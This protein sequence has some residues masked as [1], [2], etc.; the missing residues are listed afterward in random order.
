MNPLTPT[1]TK[2]AA[3]PPAEPSV[4]T[5]AAQARIQ[6]LRAM[7]E[8]IPEF[9]IP[10]SKAEARRIVA[11]ASVPPEFVELAATAITL[12]PDLRRET[13]DP[14]RVRDRMDYADAYSPLADQ[15]EAAAKFLRH[16]I[17]V[18]RGEAGSD[19]LATYALA[20]HVSRR[21]EQGELKLQVHDMERA[22]GVR[23]RLARGRAARK[24][25]AA[26][27]DGQEPLA[28]PLP[29]QQ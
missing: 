19:A 11:N 14:N 25:A 3:S 15:F 1:T 2:E 27:K 7:R 9:R 6:E 18:A 29:E 10:D 21:P 16:S 17:R 13:S 28:S 26:K 24:K 5:V 23:A 22:L 20:K 4:H 12:S 8:A